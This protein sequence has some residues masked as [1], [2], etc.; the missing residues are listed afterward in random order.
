MTYIIKLCRL[1]NPN[2]DLLKPIRITQFTMTEV[3]TKTNSN[4]VRNVGNGGEIENFAL[5]YQ[6]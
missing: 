5:S 6:E 1:L 3:I 2:A 4:D